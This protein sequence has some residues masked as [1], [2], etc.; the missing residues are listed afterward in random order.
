[1]FQINVEPL[2]LSEDFP[3]LGR[4]FSYNNNDWAVVN[5]NLHKAQRHWVM[6]AR[7]TEKTGATVRYR[8]AIYKS[9][10]KVVLF[11]SS[12]IWVVTA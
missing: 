2:T 7:A 10:E 1:M 5:Q 12:K 9:V 3:C 6:V 11:Y 8:G 4:T